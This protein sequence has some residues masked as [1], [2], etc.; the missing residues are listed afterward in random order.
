MVIGIHE[1]YHKA[2]NVS[3]NL[4]KLGF[5]IK[6]YIR[7]NFLEVLTFDENLKEENFVVSEELHWLR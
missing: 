5:I 3:A 2:T 4:Q 1:Y 6:A 7:K